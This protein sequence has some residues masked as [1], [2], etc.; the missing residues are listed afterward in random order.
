MWTVRVDLEVHG[1]YSIPLNLQE[2]KISSPAA[3][4][5]LFGFELLVST[6][7]SAERPSRYQLAQVIYNGIVTPLLST[8]QVLTSSSGSCAVSISDLKQTY[9]ISILGGGWL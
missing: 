6:I 9:Y 5:R 4:L 7:T 2:Y 3:R 8:L 1:S